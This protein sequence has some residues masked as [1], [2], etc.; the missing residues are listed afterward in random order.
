MHCMACASHRA[1]WIG[2]VFDEYAGLSY[3]TAVCSGTKAFRKMRAE[4]NTALA[5][6]EKV[7]S[8]HNATSP[9]FPKT[10]TMP[11]GFF[12]TLVQQLTSPSFLMPKPWCS[13]AVTNDQEGSCEESDKTPLAW[14]FCGRTHIR[15]NMSVQN[16]V[17]ILD[18][19]EKF[20]DH[21][22]SFS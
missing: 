7:S 5:R 14:E 15:F 20:C 8:A 12:P 21:K 9:P 19:C 2:P 3:A 11:L 18:A 22:R 10:M 1:G 17:I 13:C 16:R 6:L 4:L